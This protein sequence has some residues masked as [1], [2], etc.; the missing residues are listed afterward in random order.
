MGQHKM[1]YI[2]PARMASEDHFKHIYRTRTRAYFCICSCRLHLLSKQPNIHI[3]QMDPRPA[4]NTPLVVCVPTADATD[5]WPCAAPD[6][7]SACAIAHAIC[8][9]ALCF[10]SLNI[11]ENFLRASYAYRSRF[12]ILRLT[13]KAS[14][15]F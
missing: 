8:I 2:H 15:A 4:R 10:G 3:F 9:F 1:H 7:M 13:P 11:R 12:L 6:H 5:A 14:L